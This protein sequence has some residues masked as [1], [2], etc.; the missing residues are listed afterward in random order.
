V[1]GQQLDQVG[2][3]GRVVADP[4]PRHQPPFRVDDG[5]VVVGLCPVDPTE[6]AVLPSLPYRW[7]SGPWG[8][9]AL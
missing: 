5:D 9:R 4:L 2:E 6:H 8:T 1:S 7:L 3:P